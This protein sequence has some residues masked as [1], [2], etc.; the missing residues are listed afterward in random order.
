MIDESWYKRPPR[1]PEHI[2]AGG[3]VVRLENG[4]IQVALVREMDHPDYVLPKGHV[5]AGE[6]LERAARREIQEESGISNLNLISELGVKE[7]LDF[8]KKSWKKTY[9]FLYLT[10]QVEGVPTDK[11]HHH[12][13]WW[14][15]IDE[16][17]AMFWPEQKKFIETNCNKIMELIK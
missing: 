9:Y 5:E 10:D 3:V 11:G 8:S 14:F 4:H 15:P 13:L 6:S 12:G 16:L 1:T 17:P 7:R 2:C